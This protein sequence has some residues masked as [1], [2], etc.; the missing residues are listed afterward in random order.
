[1]ADAEKVCEFLDPFAAHCARASLWQNS[2]SGL[3]GEIRF[4]VEW[5]GGRRPPLARVTRVVSGN[6]PCRARGGTQEIL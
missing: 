3:M 4:H 5:P 6:S 2:E 1:V